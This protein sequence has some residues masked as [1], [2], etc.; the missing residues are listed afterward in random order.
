MGSVIPFKIDFFYFFLFLFNANLIKFMLKHTKAKKNDTK[1][2]ERL[3]WGFKCPL[4]DFDGVKKKQIPDWNGK[5]CFNRQMIRCNRLPFTFL[6][7]VP[8]FLKGEKCDKEIQLQ[9]KKARNQVKITLLRA[10]KIIVFQRVFPIWLGK[11]TFYQ[12]AQRNGPKTNIHF[13]TLWCRCKCS[14]K[15]SVWNE[16]HSP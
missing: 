12:V 14:K 7:N 4:I 11:A 3:Q 6:N 13:I 5:F 2:V 8:A 1:K 15:T 10:I 9:K 16:V